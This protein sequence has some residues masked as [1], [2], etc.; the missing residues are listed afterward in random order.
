V[1]NFKVHLFHY[2]PSKDYEKIFSSQ[3][4]IFSYSL[5]CLV[6][7]DTVAKVMSLILQI[8]SSHSPPPMLLKLSNSIQMINVEQILH[9]VL[10]NHEPYNPRFKIALHCCKLCKYTYK[11]NLLEHIASFF[12][13]F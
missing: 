9:N 2:I 10:L 6:A 4:L 11:Y 7:L 3:E 1:K 8:Q 12:L 5:Y 13:F